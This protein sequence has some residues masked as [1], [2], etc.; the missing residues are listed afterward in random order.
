[1][2]V[3]KY[4]VHNVMG[5]KDADLNVEGRH[6]YLVGGRN[7]QGK[8]S[9][10][11]ALLIALCGR[12]GWEYPDVPLRDGE[13]EGS[14]TVALPGDEELHEP[15]GITVER[16]FERRRD[17][18]VKETL[19]VSDSAGEPAPEPQTVLNSLYHAKGFDPLA[20]LRLNKRG[21]LEAIEKLLNL[22]GD[23]FRQSEANL[24]AE[25]KVARRAKDTAEAK[26][27]PSHPNVPLEEVSVSQLLLSLDEAKKINDSRKKTFKRIEDDRERIFQVKEKIKQIQ[28]DLA[29]FEKI[30]ADEI[31]ESDK[32]P[33]EA[34]VDAIQKKIE[35]AEE[36]NAKVRA[37]LISD[38]RSEAAKDAAREFKSLDDSIADLRL[39]WRKS[40]RDA[41]WPV[42][43]LSLDATGL[44]Y[45]DLP[46]EQAS[47]SVQIRTAVRMAMAQNP[48]LRLMVCQHGNDLDDVAMDELEKV[49][50]ES[51]FQ[52]ILEVVTRNAQDEERCAVVFENG[53]AK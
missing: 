42:E 30:L 41:E 31:A 29:R 45:N 49:L 27:V 47:R 13:D 20:F 3:L 4:E 35:D 11:T 51:D 6:L 25:R 48:K 44:L 9:A 52:M 40:L 46:F 33:P 1:M 16:K 2:K 38:E 19:V 39:E 34:D 21:Q 22:D 36:T 28:D 8:S 43:G 5:V 50:T 14:V 7:E 24:S 17:G 53:E 18:S 37:N 12:R 15:I 26:M 23:V 32:L 10:L